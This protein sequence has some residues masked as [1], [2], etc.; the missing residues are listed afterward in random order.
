MLVEGCA[1]WPAGKPIA[2]RATSFGVNYSVSPID[3]IGASPLFGTASA[4]LDKEVDTTEIDGDAP[5]LEVADHDE[6]ILAD[7]PE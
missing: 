1:F 3:G 6:A 7:V 4:A 5:P 2:L